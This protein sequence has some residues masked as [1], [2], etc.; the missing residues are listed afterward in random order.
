MSQPYRILFPL[1]IVLSWVGVGQ[2]VLWARA[3][4]DR[5]PDQRDPVE[6][7]RHMLDLEKASGQ[8]WKLETVRTYVRTVI[9]TPGPVDKPML[10]E[11]LLKLPQNQLLALAPHLC[12]ASLHRLP[13]FPWRACAS[14]RACLL[15]LKAVPQP[16]LQGLLHLLSQ[17]R[18]RLRELSS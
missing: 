3:R 11:L 15:A 2:W 6:V 4:F 16:L 18:S 13:P 9:E 8:P 14:L 10:L 12:W 1:G 7:A 5:E 17:E